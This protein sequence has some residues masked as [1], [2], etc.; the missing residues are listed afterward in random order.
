M[1]TPEEHKLMLTLF[2]KYFQ[3][4]KVIIEIL[5]S[6]GLLEGDDPMA[7]ATAVH[8]DSESNERVFQQAAA[9]YLQAAKRLGVETGLEKP[10]NP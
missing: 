8:S 9:L 10:N 7:F 1:M 3:Q 4:I 5:K 2:T 6:R